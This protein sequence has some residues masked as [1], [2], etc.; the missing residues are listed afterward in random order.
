MATRKG[1]VVS[2]LLCGGRRCGGNSAMALVA[3][4]TK[5]ASFAAAP[6]NGPLCMY[7]TAYSKKC[8]RQC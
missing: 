1:I 7:G 2:P 4:A 8:Q 6:F 3:M 5:A